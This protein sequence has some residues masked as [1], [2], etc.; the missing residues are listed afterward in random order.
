MNDGSTLVQLLSS[1]AARW[2][3]R[4]AWRHKRLG[5][6]ET[7][8]WAAF[9]RR[10]NDIARGLAVN[11]FARHDRLAVL[12]DN[13][14]DLYA[15]LLA[16]Q[17][18]GGVGVPLDPDT[19]TSRLTAIIADAR[20]SIAI[21]DTAHQADRVLALAEALPAQPRIFS[22]DIGGFS[23]RDV[24]ER[25]SLNALVEEGRGYGGGVATS[26]NSREVWGHSDPAPQDLALLLY[27]TDTQSYP[28]S[29]SHTQLITA[30]KAIVTSDPAYST[31]EAL[32][33]LPL[34]SYEDVL[35]SLT[36]GLLCGFACNCPEAPDSTLCDLREIG[37]T[38]LFAPTAAC[39]ALAQIVSSKAEVMTGLKRCSF[40]FFHRLGLRAD[41]RREQDRTVPVGLA[42]G[43]RIGELMVYAPARDQI[44]LSRARW[45]H[46]DALLPS[47]TARLLRALGIALRPA[48]ALTPAPG[49]AQERHKTLHA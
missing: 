48:N 17:S 37:P 35:Y 20:V 31:D 45:V 10:C 33:Y 24:W 26:P 7:Q 38:I 29:L 1:N 27:S 15:A 19:D 18:L 4:P 22:A 44:G 49:P 8:N 3:N 32:C 11:G 13:R 14:P 5:I 40:R 21:T 30:A 42:I 6:W 39:N 34:S 46:T 12:G 28:L 36:L 43:C 2:P 23:R 9:A 41:A 25:S 47:D 16:A